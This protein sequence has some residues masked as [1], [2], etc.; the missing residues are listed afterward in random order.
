[1]QGADRVSVRKR[2]VG[3]LRVRERLF[4]EVDRDGVEPWIDLVHARNA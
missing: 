4:G 1:M 3:E 2:L